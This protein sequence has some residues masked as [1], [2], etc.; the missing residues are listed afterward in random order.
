MSDAIEKTAAG[1]TRTFFGALGFILL[2]V[3]VEGMTGQAPLTLFSA[4]V[5]MA[6]GALCF[7]LAFFWERAKKH[8][9]TETQEM[10][11][12]FA[13]SRVTKFGM[14][15][16]V[17]ETLILSPFFEQHRWPFSYPADPAVYT[18]IDSLKNELARRNSAFGP[19]KESAD[20]WRFSSVLRQSGLNCQYKLEWSPRANSVA[21]FWREL[22]V[23]TGW[24]GSSEPTT[25]PT[26]Y[27]ITIR[28]KDDPASTQC[29]EVIQRELS[30]FYPNPAA[31]IILHQQTEFLNSCGRNNCVQIEVD[32]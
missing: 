6:L 17:L 23:A 19:E 28:A 29:A 30:D 24:P 4:A 32:Y 12:R 14:L 16:L 1:A 25:S 21:A 3:G 22:F 27:G 10:I 7:Y 9:S 18:Q 11:G 13:Q 20:K 8:L 26:Q 15:F 2:M 5:C 31:K